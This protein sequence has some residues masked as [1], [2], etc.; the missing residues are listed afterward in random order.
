MLAVISIV[1]AINGSKVSLRWAKS[2]RNDFY[3]YF[4]E[5]RPFSRI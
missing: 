1:A 5:E 4:Q 2:M 3:V